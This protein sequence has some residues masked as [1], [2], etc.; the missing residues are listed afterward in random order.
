MLVC[1]LIWVYTHISLQ[2]FQ[3]FSCNALPDSVDG[4]E[5]GVFWFQKSYRFHRAFLVCVCVCVI[6]ECEES[7]AFELFLREKKQK[8]NPAYN[9]RFRTL[10]TYRIAGKR[11]F[12][13][14]V[15][16]LTRPKSILQIRVFERRKKTFFFSA[17]YR[18]R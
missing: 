8:D 5:G 9:T 3:D 1:R 13:R 14:F 4:G 10:T 15:N 16:V 11:R 2:E 18:A 6:Y 17:Y 7:I 12:A